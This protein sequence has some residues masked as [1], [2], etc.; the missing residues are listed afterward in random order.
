METKPHICPVWIGYIMA[1]PLR[2]LQQNPNKI[3]A[4][5]IKEGMNILE[6]GPAMGFFSI[7][8]AKMTGNSGKVYCADIQENMLTKLYRRASK[9][10]VNHII[11]TRLTSSDSLNI[12]D[13]KNSIDFTI[14][15]FVVHEVPD[16][17]NLFSAVA[18]AMKKNSSLLFME[19]K[20]HVNMLEWEKSISIAKENGLQFEQNI[21]VT[22]SRAAL[23]K[24]I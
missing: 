19:P 11:E 17:N 16:Q 20:G 15:A 18:E 7:P 4:P 13:L 3:L 2:K 10:G 24:K 21:K 23:L 5:F 22:G 14:L 8:M 9:A 12:D 6:I 1:S